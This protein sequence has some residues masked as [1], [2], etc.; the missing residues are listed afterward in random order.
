MLTEHIWTEQGLVNGTLGPVRDII[1]K[2]NADWRQQ[3]PYAILTTFDQDEGPTLGTRQPAVPIFRSRREF[4]RG[5]TVCT[6]IQFPLTNAYAITVHKAQGMTVNKAVLDLST[7][8][9]TPGLSYVAVSRVKTLQGILF[10]EPFD[11]E[12]FRTTGASDTV[13]W[14]EADRQRRLSEHL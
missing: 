12:H 14:R 2:V 8:D 1:W 3:P 6:R 11:Y 7:R 13:T 9:F 4:Y 10:D 5:N